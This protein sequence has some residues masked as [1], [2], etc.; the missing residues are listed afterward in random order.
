MYSSVEDLFNLP[1]RARR[2]RVV[3]C[4]DWQ[5]NKGREFNSRARQNNKII[6]INK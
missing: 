6:I 2:E 4:T 5:R 1:C 3:M